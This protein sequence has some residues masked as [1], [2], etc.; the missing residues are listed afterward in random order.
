VNYPTYI[1]ADAT[2][3]YWANATTGTTDVSIVRAKV[4]GSSPVVLAT[5][6]G[7][8]YGLTTD[9]TTIYFTTTNGLVAS[10]PKNSD[11]T[12]APTVIASTEGYPLG[13]AVDDT[14]IYW[15]DEGHTSIRHHA[16]NGTTTDTIG[17]TK[18]NKIDV[19]LGSETYLT[20]D[21][22]HVYWT[23]SGTQY[24]HGAVIS[25]TRN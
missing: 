9:S 22:T 23:D 25:L 10:V 3:V 14:D 4:D 24:S 12:A 18:L 5:G 6:Q 19:F 2:Y 17:T 13:I 16:K 7:P 1:A 15:I 20:L 11:G 8:I 21:A